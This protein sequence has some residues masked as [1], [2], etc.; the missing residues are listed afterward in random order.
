M[1]HDL[2]LIE[3]DVLEELLEKAFT[4]DIEHMSQVHPPASEINK[5][6]QKKKKDFLSGYVNIPLDLNES[7]A[8][9]LEKMGYK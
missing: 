5:I 6:V 2:T 8:D 4:Y 1:T 7:I 3:T 9:G